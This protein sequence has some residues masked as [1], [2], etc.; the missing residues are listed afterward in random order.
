MSHEPGDFKLK[1]SRQDPDE[2]IISQVVLLINVQSCTRG[3]ERDPVATPQKSYVVSL[4]FG[5]V[6]T[7]DEIEQSIFSLSKT[8]TTRAKSFCEL[9]LVEVVLLLLNIGLVVVVLLLVLVLVLLS[10][11]SHIF[12]VNIFDA[13][14]INSFLVIYSFGKA[15]ASG[16]ILI[17]HISTAFCAYPYQ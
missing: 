2:V 11:T 8:L 16:R 5:K 13:M 1:L 10:F 7:L 17:S 15:F 3:A 12:I 9:L 6:V 14:V 4:L